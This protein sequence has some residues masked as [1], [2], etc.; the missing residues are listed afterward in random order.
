MIA[1]LRR[2]ADGVTPRDDWRNRV[3]EWPGVTAAELSRWHGRLLAGDWIEPN[4]VAA[5]TVAAGELPA[6]YR[7]TAAGRRAAGG[8][9]HEPAPATPVAA[10]CG[11]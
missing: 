9:D 4:I 6:C 8:P 11:R 1:L 5:P 2:Y 7:A 3:M 10:A